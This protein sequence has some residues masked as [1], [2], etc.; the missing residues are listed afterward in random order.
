[1]VKIARENRKMPKEGTMGD[2]GAP[3]RKTAPKGQK[4]GDGIKH[5]LTGVRRKPS[6]DDQHIAES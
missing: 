1:V 5:P 6:N 3:R 4:R 2:L